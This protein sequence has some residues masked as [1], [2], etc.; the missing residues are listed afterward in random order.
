MNHPNT[1]L[2]YRHMGLEGPEVNY[3]DF[4]E[5]RRVMEDVCERSERAPTLL[6]PYRLDRVDATRPSSSLRP[7]EERKTSTA[8]PVNDD[9]LHVK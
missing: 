1:S 9:D 8:L 4:I 6:G 5:G 2:K 7:P 3:E